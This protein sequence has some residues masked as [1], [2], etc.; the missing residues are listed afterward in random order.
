MCEFCTKHGDGK[1]WYKNASNYSQDL[2]SD[3]RR[4]IF[5]ENFLET[6]I[7]DGFQTLGRIEALFR[8]KGRLPDALV[9]RMEDRAKTE[10]FGQVLPIE[11][12]RDV[13]LKA[14]TV[15]RM[16]CACRWTAEKREVRC[17][18]GIALGPEPWYA[19]IDMSYFGK[20]PEEGLESL[21]GDEAMRQMEEMEDHGAVHTIWTMMT[22]FIGA[23]CNC[24]A[25][26]CL[27]MRTLSGI[28]VETMARAEHV[29]V[30][31]SEL[32]SGCGLCEERCQFSAI[33]SRR[34]GGRIGAVI[35][36]FKC[37]GCGLCRKACDAGAISLQM[38]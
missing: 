29:A 6:T 21:S 5:I 3:L 24:S 10:H 31:A 33:E 14:E 18:Y 9:R 7:R 19:G 32:C 15:V 36:G 27:A 26:D 28:R 17:C 37:Y 34:D 4:R 22:P 11:E 38:R 16:P 13:V 23:V 1:I 8:K 35:N 25:R 12:I 20:A 2:L 30:V